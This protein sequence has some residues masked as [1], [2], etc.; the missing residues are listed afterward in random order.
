MKT[1]T[2][3]EQLAILRPSIGCAA[4]MHLWFL[5]GAAIG[6]VVAIIFWHPVP[7]MIAIFLGIVGSS[8][9]KAGP[10]IVAALIAYDTGTPTCGEIS[11][12]ITSWDTDNHYYATVYE[13]GHAA[14]KYEFVPQGWQPTTGRYPANIW[15]NDSNDTPTLAVVAEGIL[16][17]RYR[18][19]IL[20]ENP[21]P[22]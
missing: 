17:P 2:V 15:R 18:P 16:I 12:T 10:N 5:A 22:E 1:R 14:W 3:E 11:I 19:K 13:Q 8:E 6:V 20:F 4:H 21:V 9:H 7:L